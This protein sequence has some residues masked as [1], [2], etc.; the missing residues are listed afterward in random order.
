MNKRI[1]QKLMLLA[2]ELIHIDKIVMGVHVLHSLIQ[3]CPKHIR[4]LLSE[5]RDAVDQAFP[6]RYGWLDETSL[7]C[8]LRSLDG[9]AKGV[10]QTN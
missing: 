2:P 10:K 9:P 4:S 7:H 1:Y 6:G 8:T 3:L 5:F